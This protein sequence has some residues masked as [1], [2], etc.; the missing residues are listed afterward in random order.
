MTGGMTDPAP[1][2]GPKSEALVQGAT[3][4]EL[5]EDLSKLPASWEVD[6]VDFYEQRT[7]ATRTVTVA[8]GFNPPKE[9]E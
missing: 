4:E 8:I 5:L 2:K 1:R 9:G 6:F 3:V 7:L